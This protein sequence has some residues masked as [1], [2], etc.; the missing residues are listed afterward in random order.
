MFENDEKVVLEFGALPAG[1]SAGSPSATT[2]HLIDTQ[3]VSFGATSYSATKGGP[4]ATVT[5]NVDYAPGA[6]A[7]VCLVVE[8]HAGTSDDDYAGV[9]DELVF[10]VTE[11]SRSFVVTVADEMRLGQVALA[12]A[13]IIIVKLID[14]RN[15][16]QPA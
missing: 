5:V 14:W 3:T 7:I 16:H 4:G 9:P 15:R 1:I 11:T 13:L 10:A 2:F 6:P 12:V 8:N